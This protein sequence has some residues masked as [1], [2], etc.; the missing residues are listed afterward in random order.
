MTVYVV[1]YYNAG[2]WGM[3]ELMLDSAAAQNAY[4]WYQTL[5]GTTYAVIMSWQTTKGQTWGTP[6]AGF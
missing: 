5:N 3:S 1:A 4:N 2:T 6:P